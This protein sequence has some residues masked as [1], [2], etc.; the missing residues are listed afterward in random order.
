LTKV[1]VLEDAEALLSERQPDNQESV[2]SLLNI[3]DGFLGDFLQMHVICTINAPIGRLD[4]AVKRADRLIAVRRFDRLTWSQVQPLAAAHGL[5]MEF[6]ET[7]S[8]AEI[9]A[10]SSLL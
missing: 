8:L 6:R 5:T 4:P 3:G 10:N 1:V 9:Y 2:S 7:Y